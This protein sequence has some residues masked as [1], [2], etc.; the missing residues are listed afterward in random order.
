MIMLKE[1]DTDFMIAM[2]QSPYG[3]AGR[4][5]KEDLSWSDPNFNKR[6]LSAFNHYGINHHGIP[7]VDTLPNIL[8]SPADF[9]AYPYHRTASQTKPTSGTTTQQQTV[10]CKDYIHMSSQ[11]L[12]EKVHRA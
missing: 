3:H 1:G 8:H 10:D 9:I 7:P 12:I 2:L 6:L 5:L 11:E 4:P